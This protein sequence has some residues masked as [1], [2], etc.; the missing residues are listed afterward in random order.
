MIRK[1][2]AF[3]VIGAV[4]SGCTTAPETTADQVRLRDQAGLT[5]ARFKAA[6][7]TLETFFEESLGYAV[8]PTI[9]KGGIG[10]GGAHGHGILY[11]AGR[12]IGFCDV[13]QGT[14]GIQF[15][16]QGYSQVIFFEIQESLEQFKR[17]SFELAAQASGV[18]VR[19]GGA[20]TAS[21]ESGVAIFTMPRAGFMFEATV[22]G[23]GFSYLPFSEVA[24]TDDSEP[25]PSK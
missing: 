5:I 18:A 6:D 3:I 12:Q 22:G 9:A 25:I 16:G 14:I 10:I 20:A 13:S 24:S 19:A 17:G 15:G 23:Q 11:E 4:L 2:A 21:Y 8:F 7:P 1:L